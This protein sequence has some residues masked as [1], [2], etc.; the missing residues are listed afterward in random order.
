MAM[1]NVEWVGSRAS[2][3]FVGTQAHET[4]ENYQRNRILCP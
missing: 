4:D 1:K 2:L 3:S